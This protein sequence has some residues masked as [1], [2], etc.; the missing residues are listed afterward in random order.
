MSSLRGKR[1]RIGGLATALLS[2]VLAL[3]PHL[4]VRADRPSGA[5]ATGE[6]ITVEAHEFLLDPNQPQRKNFG[7]LIWRGGIVLSSSARAFGGFSGLDI[8]EDGKRLIAISDRGAWLFAD[9]RYDGGRLGGLNNARLGTLMGPKGAPLSDKEDADAEGL[10]VVKRKG[11]GGTLLVSFERRHRIRE[12]AFSPNGVTWQ[13]GAIRLP[14]SA[15]R[16]SRNKGLEGLTLINRGRLKGTIIAFAERLKHKSGGLMGWLIGGPT[17]GTI[18]LKRLNGFDITD[19]ATL[20][21]GDVLVLE[22]RF[23]MSA[24]IRMRIR[25]IPVKAIRPGALLLSGE[26]LFEAT[27]ALNIDNME[28]I[29]VHR[30]RSGET[31]ITVISD[32]NFN[33]F[34]RTLL[35]QFVLPNR[36]A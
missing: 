11:G 23:R 22:R 16:L 26:I 29:A 3:S 13:T 32:D 5:V 27:G 9:I 25:R 7:K 14:R 36:A 4:S 10:V 31:V 2:A 12:Y 19:L 34:Q 15:N 24:D 30:S 18:R 8:D 33:F 6:E 17:P 1:M 35:M 21:N 28:G 20:P